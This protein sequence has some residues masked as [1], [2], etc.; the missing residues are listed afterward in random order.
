MLNGRLGHQQ[1]GFVSVKWLELKARYPPPPTATHRTPAAALFPTGRQLA[2][3]RPAPASSRRAVNSPS[4]SMR[5]STANLSSAL[6]PTLNQP[7]PSPP[8]GSSA[9]TA[10]SAKPTGAS[11]TNT[12]TPSATSSGAS[13]A[14]QFGAAQL[15]A[16]VTAPEIFETYEQQAQLMFDVLPSPS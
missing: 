15:P 2:R 11:S 3:A 5:P 8:A 6:K 14:A 12:S 7:P 9:S 4:R 16:G 10:P 13:R 1:P